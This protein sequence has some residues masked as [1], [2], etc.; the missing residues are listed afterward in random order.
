MIKVAV[1]GSGLMGSSHAARIGS[2]AEYA[3]T[4]RALQRI[5]DE[6]RVAEMV[7]A[8][9]SPSRRRP[10]VGCALPGPLHPLA[11]RAGAAA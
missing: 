9:Y 4:L 10:A 2:G 8:K 3:R 6:M 7:E 11:A 5:G 1:L